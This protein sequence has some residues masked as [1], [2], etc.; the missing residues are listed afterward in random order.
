MQNIYKQCC[1]VKAKNG[2]RC[3]YKVHYGDNCSDSDFCKMHQK[4]QNVKRFDDDLDIDSTKNPQTKK[5]HNSIGRIIDVSL[6][7]RLKIGSVRI[8][9]L[10]RTLGYY[11][12]LCKGNKSSLFQIVHNHLLSIHPYVGSIDKIIGIQSYYRKYLLDRLSKLQGNI[13]SDLSIC[14]N[15]EDVKSLDPLI[16]IPT[17]LLFSFQEED[18]TH[19][20]FD[21]RTI[22]S[23][24]TFDNENP[25][26]RVALST[27]IVDRANETL[28][29]LSLLQKDTSD[30]P[31]EVIGE[32]LGLKR[33]VVKIF[34]EM[35]QLDQYTDPDW[36]LSLS[37]SRLIKFYKEAED[38]W[39]YRL[40]LT[41]D[42]KKAIVPHDGIAFRHSVKAV[43]LMKDKL[44]LQK[45]CLDFIDTLIHSA[46]NKADRVNGCIYVLLG[47]VQVNREAAK[48]LPQ[49]YSMVMG[50][51]SLVTDTDILI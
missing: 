51:D 25:Y 3:S 20:G 27:R 15:Q 5:N 7:P 23:I 16:D 1:A 33:R 21:I 35:D 9:D 47:L 6:T 19:Y 37:V 36:F 17:H 29:L 26:T 45:I 28:R 18:G 42:V 39:N 38:V 48:A 24:I 40:N 31:S 30:E 46:S 34:H 4:A 32:E 13:S 44:L 43:C 8:N 22:R 12:L 10:K 50:D 14:V 41:G 11:R 2:E 49:Y